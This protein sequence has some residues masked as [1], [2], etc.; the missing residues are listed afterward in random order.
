MAGNNKHKSKDNLVWLDCEMTGLDPAVHTILE[1]AAVITDN[2]LEIIAESP[3]IAILQ[4]EAALALMDR[5]NITH[6][7]KS[8]LLAQVR[9]STVSTEQAEAHIL[10]FVRKYCYKG[11]SPLC[12][13]C[14]GHDR[15]FLAKYMPKLHAYFHYQSIDVSSLKQLAM[16]WYPSKNHAPVKTDTHRVLTDIKESIEELEYY[17]KRFLVRR[18]RGD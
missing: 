14:I 6:H 1:I 16:R 17:R 5:W 12:G 7:N 10:Q 9:I 11:Y 3:A 13:N 4:D 18:V 8:G 2:D 15:G